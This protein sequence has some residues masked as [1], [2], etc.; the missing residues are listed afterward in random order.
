M[1]IVYLELGK[2]QISILRSDL[3]LMD[4]FSAA[5]LFGQKPDSNSFLRS[6]DWFKSDQWKPRYPKMEFPLLP[7]AGDSILGHLG[8]HWSDLS[9]SGLY[10]KLFKSGFRPNR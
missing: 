6:P 2:I 4:C 1:G 10:R 7:L 9:Q 8:F 5:C 3:G